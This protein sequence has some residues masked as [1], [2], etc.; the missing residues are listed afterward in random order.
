MQSGEY[1]MTH[2]KPAIHHSDGDNNP[3]SLTQLVILSLTIGNTTIQF[4]VKATKSTE[5]S[6]QKQKFK[7][8]S[9]VIA[10]QIWICWLNLLEYLETIF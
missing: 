7:K 5:I 9:F 3:H 1:W 2:T 4:L 10:I 6:L 8:I